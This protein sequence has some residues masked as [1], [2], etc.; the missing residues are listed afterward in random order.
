METTHIRISKNQKKFLNNN[1]LCNNESYSNVI[2]RMI[3][4]KKNNT[5]KCKNLRRSK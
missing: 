3:V 1:K 5:N 2:D 4:K